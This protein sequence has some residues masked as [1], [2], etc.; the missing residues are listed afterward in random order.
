MRKLFRRREFLTRGARHV[1]EAFATAWIIRSWLDRDWGGA[2]TWLWWLNLVLSSIV[3]LAMFT[4]LF[5]KAKVEPP[6]PT[7]REIVDRY[8]EHNRF[9]LITREQAEHLIPG[10]H[11]TPYVAPDAAVFVNP[12]V[13]KKLIDTWPKPVPPPQPVDKATLER[14]D[15]LLPPHA[16]PIRDTTEDPKGES[17]PKPKACGQE[18]FTDMRCPKRHLHDGK[19][20]CSRNKAHLIGPDPRCLCDCGKVGEVEPS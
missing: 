3:A 11:A 17:V 9:M 18:W 5:T 4:L 14:L 20:R 1:S 19:H 10:V 15:L 12:A 7:E 16:R 6:A 8:L 13:L 2:G